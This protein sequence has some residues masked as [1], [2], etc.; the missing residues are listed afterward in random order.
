MAVIPISLPVDSLTFR[1]PIREERSKFHEFGIPK[2][3]E[4]EEA[5][6]ESPPRRLRGWGEPGDPNGRAS[7]LLISGIPGSP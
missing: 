3:P 4:G 6:Q 5:A 7:S 2:R 1:P